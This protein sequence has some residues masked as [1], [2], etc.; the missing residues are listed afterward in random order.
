MCERS[1]IQDL[2]EKSLA[3]FQQECI[4]VG[5]APSAAVAVSRGG[6]SSQGGVCSW[7]GVCSGGVSALGGVC[8]GGCLLLG[9][10]S[11]PGG[12]LLWGV[13]ALGGVCSWGYLLLGAAPRGGV[14]S[15]GCLLQGVS[16]PG[17]SAPGGVC[18][19]GCLLLGGVSHHALRQTPPRGQTD[20]CKNITFATSLRTVNMNL[21]PL[22]KPDD[23]IKFQFAWMI[24]Q[25]AQTKHSKI[26]IHLF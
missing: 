7:G 3:K 6:V 22:V 4:P 17:V 18:S 21:R 2:A 9:G 16:A 10:V 23:Q 5:C 24:F 11:A 26:Q 25:L 8:S 13:S 14:C 12:C 15:G 20:A 19:G 1:W